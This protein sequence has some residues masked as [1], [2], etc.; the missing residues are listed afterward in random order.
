[1]LPVACTAAEQRVY[2]FWTSGYWDETRHEYY[3][4]TT[5]GD[6]L[7]PSSDWTRFYFRNNQE[8][9]LLTPN[10]GGIDE[11]QCSDLKPYICEKPEAV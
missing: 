5:D 8:C 9:V 1:M 11:H 7:I 10:D 3:W 4:A 6:E 2:E